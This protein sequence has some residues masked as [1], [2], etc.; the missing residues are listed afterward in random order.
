[1][2]RKTHGRYTPKIVKLSFGIDN[3]VVPM[4]NAAMIQTLNKANLTIYCKTS[5]LQQ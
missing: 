1:M 5:Q 3:S 4:Q 2:I